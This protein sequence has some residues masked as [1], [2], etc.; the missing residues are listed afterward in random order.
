VSCL[1]VPF[2]EVHKAPHNFYIKEVMQ[3]TNFI[4]IMLD[5]FNK[6]VKF[7]FIALLL[8]VYL[9]MTAKIFHI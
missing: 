1:S 8:L 2:L 5:E 9:K 4:V 3:G 6:F 7:H